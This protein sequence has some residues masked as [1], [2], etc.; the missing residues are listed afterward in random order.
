MSPLLDLPSRPV[1]GMAHI[2]G[3]GL[4][5]NI[6]RILPAGCAVEL[7][8]GAWQI[9][10]L[11]RLIQSK[12]NVP[13]AEMRRVFNMGLG[14]IVIVSAD[15][16]EGIIGGT[17]AFIKVGSVVEQDDERVVFTQ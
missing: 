15:E 2:T 7:N 9:P 17:P 10:P 6:P 5:D 12:G 3:G 4:V 8:T 16:A 1:K 13:D 14:M 11:F